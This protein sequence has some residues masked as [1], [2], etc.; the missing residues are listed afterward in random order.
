ME[1]F[2]SWKASKHRCKIKAIVGL[3]TVLF[4]FNR[5]MFSKFKEFVGRNDVL[6]LFY[7]YRDTNLLIF[8]LCRVYEVTT[9]VCLLLENTPRGVFSALM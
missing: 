3:K 2:I 1:S 4:Q 9:V 8:N 5:Q 6:S 7:Q